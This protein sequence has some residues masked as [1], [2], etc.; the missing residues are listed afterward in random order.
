MRPGLC[1][2]H[3]ILA[4]GCATSALPDPAAP[5]SYETTSVDDTYMAGTGDMVPMHA[6]FPTDKTH[7]PYPI[8]VFGH[9]FQIPVTQYT[10]Y[11]T[12]LA[13]FGYVAVT[14]DYPDPFMG[15]VNNLNDGADL[16][17]ALDWAQA[18]PAT[19]GMVDITRAGVMGHSRGGKAAV[20]AALADPRFK[21]VYGVDPVDAPPPGGVSCMPADACPMAYLEVES[22]HVPSLFVGETLDSV[23]G[24]LACAPAAGNYAVFYAHANAP[25][26]EVTVNG[27]SHMS[28][29]DDPTT[30]GVVCELCQTP[31]LPQAKALGLAQAYAVAFFERYLRGRT[32]YDAYLTGTDVVHQYIQ[33]GVATVASK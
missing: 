20:L 30:C 7:A 19:R 4:S 27:A 15:P 13:S 3:L 17:S 10:D 24:A 12:H 31:T 14:A 25:S 23:G 8:V 6:V 22:L 11:L 33:P 16:A 9:G 1:A 28:F 18:S 29:V 21:A 5:G 26:I 2:V 32:G